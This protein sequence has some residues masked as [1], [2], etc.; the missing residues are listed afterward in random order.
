M[1]IFSLF[2]LCLAVIILIISVIIQIVSVIYVGFFVQTTGYRIAWAIFALA[3]LF[4]AIRNILFLSDYFQGGVSNTQLAEEI[5]G[6]V[7]SV[8]FFIGLIKIKPIFLHYQKIIEDLDVSQKKY[9][10]ILRG[11]S[12]GI[13]IIQDGKIKF[14]NPRAINLLGYPEQE[15]LDK[16][17]SDFVEPAFRSLI[18]EKYQ[19]RIKGKI[20][21]EEQYEVPVIQKA[22][23][24]LLVELNVSL[25][26]YLDKPAI[27]VIG[28]DITVRKQREQAVNG[29]SAE[30]MVL[31][32]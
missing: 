28:R 25:I 32:V 23:K 19:L 20:V 18:E 12:D 5:F 31:L 30:M 24:I 1:D 7:I 21:N 3:F 10:T 27:L 6:L 11:S 17:F 22:G 8:L 4:R 9:L 15:I 2:I 13:V 16:R 29:G 14:V 26:D